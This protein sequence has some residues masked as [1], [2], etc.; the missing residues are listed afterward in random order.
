MVAAR[1]PPRAGTAYLYHCQTFPEPGR[2][3][4]RRVCGKLLLSPDVPEN[5]PDLRG[6]WT[7][8]AAATVSGRRQA[9]TVRAAGDNERSSRGSVGDSV[10]NWASDVTSGVTEVTG[11]TQV[12]GGTRGDPPVPWVDDAWQS[13]LF[14]FTRNIVLAL[15]LT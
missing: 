6:D 2:T 15:F 1:A 11:V 5:H 14:S 10:S 9:A 13:Q 8:R 3:T 7:G 4:E 12:T